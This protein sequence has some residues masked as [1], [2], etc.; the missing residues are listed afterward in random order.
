MSL[1]RAKKKEYSA[2]DSRNRVKCLE[3]I[4]TNHC[5]T[6]DFYAKSKIQISQFNILF[7]GVVRNRMSSPY[8]TTSVSS[9][10]TLTG[11]PKN[12]IRGLIELSPA[13]SDN[14][15]KDCETVQCVRPELQ[16]APKS[17]VPL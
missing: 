10:S 13:R 2:A 4:H 14:R 12:V 15:R 9:N 11:A 8:Y 5:T 17:R 1:K 3:G 6:A 16:E 7:C